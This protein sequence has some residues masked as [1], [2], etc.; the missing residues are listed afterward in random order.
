MTFCNTS[1]MLT[2]LN[3]VPRDMWGMLEA[4]EPPEPSTMH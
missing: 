4:M 2:H 1:C 3:D